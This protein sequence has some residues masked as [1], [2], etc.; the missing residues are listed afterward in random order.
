MLQFSA[1]MMCADYGHLE[2][3]VKALEDAGVD[4]FHIDI[5]DGHF[6]DNFGMGIHDLRY[7]RSVTKKPVEV[8]LMIE[9]PRHYIDLFAEI[10]VDVVYIHPESEYHIS[11]T[12]EKIVRKG[13]KPAIVI[14]PGTSP[15]SIRELLNIVQ[16][17]LVMSVNPGFAGQTFLPFVGRKIEKL[18]EMQE[19]FDFEIFWDG[20]AS[21]ENIQKYAPMGV[22]GF[23]LGTAA[24]FGKQKSFKEI[25]AE[26]RQ[27][28][29]R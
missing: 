13:M 15:S 14:N 8:H 23:I 25:I 4:S 19:E 1:S 9:E 17:V 3:E 27:I 22:N 11:A 16:R 10:G 29:S 28:K 26:L 2:K 18:I 5:M 12:I 20:H 7:I 6:V 24:L 21:S